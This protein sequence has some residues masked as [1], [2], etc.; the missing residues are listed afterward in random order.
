M[1]GEA[2][3]A[4][5][6]SVP[7]PSPPDGPR[8]DGA[9]RNRPELDAMSLAARAAR[10]MSL[11]MPPASRRAPPSEDTM[12]LK[13]IWA[14]RWADSRRSSASIISPIGPVTRVA[15]ATRFTPIS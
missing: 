14:S 10:S 3:G 1:N 11:A 4:V 7:P 5:R 6:V 13:P 8:G 9:D 12:L 15:L 2:A